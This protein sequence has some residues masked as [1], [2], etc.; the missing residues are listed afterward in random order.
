MNKHDDNHSL[1]KEDKISI[2]RKYKELKSEFERY[3][4]ESRSEYDFYNLIEKSVLEMEGESTNR[5]SNNE[6]E[7]KK[8]GMSKDDL[9]KLC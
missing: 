3:R 8:Y 9:N 5:S 7:L 6:E 4:S 1:S 2:S